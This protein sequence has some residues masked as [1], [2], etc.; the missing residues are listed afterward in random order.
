MDGDSKDVVII[1]SGSKFIIEL[2]KTIH[3]IVCKQCVYR[4]HFYHKMIFVVHDL[5]SK[6]KYLRYI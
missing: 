1:F 6:C 2:E 4:Q 5:K 3:K